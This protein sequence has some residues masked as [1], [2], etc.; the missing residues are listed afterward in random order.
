MSIVDL[1][2]VLYPTLYS[3][4]DLP[5]DIGD[6]PPCRAEGGQDVDVEVEGRGVEGIWGKP[7]PG[8]DIPSPLPPTSEK[9]VS[10]GV[11]LLDVGDEMLIYVGYTVSAEVMY[12]LFGVDV[13][14]GEA[15]GREE[16][17]C[18]LFS[19]CELGNSYYRELLAFRFYTFMVSVF[20]SLYVAYAICDEGQ[21][22]KYL[23]T[24][25]TM[26]VG[27]VCR[28]PYLTWT[29]RCRRT[30]V[31]LSSS[32][33]GKGA[34][35]LRLREDEGYEQARRVRNVIAHLRRGCSTFKPLVIVVGN[36]GAPEEVM[37]TSG[38]RSRFVLW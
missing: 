14:A 2:Q 38:L 4:H 28:L 19:R 15:I 24:I 13:P 33:Y 23:R 26:H 3:L 36:S 11:F 16:I 27:G 10:D 21:V 32:G 8:V 30:P 12:E 1:V 37:E 22:P 31:G 9:L 18:F 25:T 34:A 35:R 20:E 7:R 6:A 17:G 29:N 5:P